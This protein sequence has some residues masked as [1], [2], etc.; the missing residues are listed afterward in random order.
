M[1]VVPFHCGEIVVQE[2]AGSR[3]AAAQLAHIL[4]TELPPQARTFL[5]AQP[6]LVLGSADER[7]RLWTSVITGPPGFL[8]AP[9]AHTLHIAAQPVPGDILAANLV[10]D[11]PV[12]ISV[13]DFVSRRRIRLNGRAHRTQ[14]AITVALDEVFFNCP[15]YIQARQWR[16]QPAPS[17]P[18]H[19]GVAARALSPA[20]QD[21][22]CAADTFFLAS[23]HP[24]AGFDVSH[25]GGRPGFVQV[26]NSQTLQWPDYMGNGMFQTLGNL[27]LA[28]RAGLL[29]PDFVTGDVFQLTGWA[30][31]D[32]TPDH[33]RL[34]A[35][36]ER[37]VTFRVEEVRVLPQALPFQWTFESYS[38]FNPPAGTCGS[39]PAE[40]Q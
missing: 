24:R 16:A 15:K 1:K 5:A 36:A 2:R 35:G 22:I 38:P 28:P 25:R 26:L 17:R 20:L 4:Q 31:V 37:L 27:A 3:S 34:D 33:A 7:G 18:A 23:A 14:A 30:H 6:L 40:H 13:V 19:G 21:A 10:A 12:G 39:K 11:A 32:W 8:Q 9:D 29:F